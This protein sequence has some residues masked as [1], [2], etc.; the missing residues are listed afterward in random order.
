M[1]I[2]HGGTFPSPPRNELLVACRNVYAVA[3]DDFAPR[4]PLWVRRQPLGLV[5]IH[6]AGVLAIRSSGELAVQKFDICPVL[7]EYDDSYMA[8]EELP[9][10]HSP[11][12][13]GL[14]V[15]DLTPLE[16]AATY[17][18]VDKR[19][20]ALSYKVHDFD[21]HIPEDATNQ[22]SQ[23]LEVLNRYVAGGRPCRSQRVESSHVDGW[24]VGHVIMPRLS[25]HT[26]L[27]GNEPPD[28]IRS[29]SDFLNTKYAA[30]NIELDTMLGD[31]SRRI[32]EESMQVDTNVAKDRVDEAISRAAE[33]RKRTLATLKRLRSHYTDF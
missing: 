13:M 17:G 12:G 27:E 10:T 6:F 31:R 5:A 11:L 18:T 26:V 15:Y 14:R 33:E 20:N 30:I 22:A 23:F 2:S 4:S 21:V 9:P 24:S 19:N 1:V 28:F 25:V 29:L 7:E 8:V 32:A 16:I 3:M